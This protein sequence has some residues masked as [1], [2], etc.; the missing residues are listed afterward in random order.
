MYV[1]AAR[2]ARSL[3]DPYVGNPA[4][5]V[6]ADAADGS[7]EKVRDLEKLMQAAEML[8]TC[9]IEELA[10]IGKL[11]QSQIIEMAKT[12]TAAS[13]RAASAL[14]HETRL[15][16]AHLDRAFGLAPKAAAAHKP[17]EWSLDRL[18]KLRKSA[19]KSA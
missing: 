3:A 5:Q 13:M 12:P 11:A 7:P 1:N 17:G 19:K 6:N 2:A 14:D 18:E 4:D 16:I 15:A 10:E 9:G 8:A